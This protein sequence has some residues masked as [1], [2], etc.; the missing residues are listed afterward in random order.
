MQYIQ[1]LIRE[2]HD[3]YH[4]TSIVY[5]LKNPAYGIDV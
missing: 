2:R 3:C 4:R 1:R 5:T